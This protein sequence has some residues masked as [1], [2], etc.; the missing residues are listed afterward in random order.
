MGHWAQSA[1]LLLHKHFRSGPL[2]AKACSCLTSNLPLSAAQFP[3]HAISNHHFM[4]TLCWIQL[5]L[6]SIQWHGRESHMGTSTNARQESLLPQRACDLNRQGSWWVGR[7]R[8]AGK[9]SDLLR[10]KPSVNISPVSP[11]LYLCDL[12][13]AWVFLTYW[14]SILWMPLEFQY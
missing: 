13:T 4:S 3:G 8:G 10:A 12:C 7:K 2:A 11:E 5:L 9:G 1:S 14:T 6:K